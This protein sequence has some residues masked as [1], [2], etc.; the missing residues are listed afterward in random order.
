MKLALVLPVAL[1]A[2]ASCRKV[3]VIGPEVE[4]EDGTTYYWA[5]GDRDAERVLVRKAPNSPILETLDEGVFRNVL[6]PV[7]TEGGVAWATQDSGGA[8]R[9]EQTG[10]SDL[11]ARV[12]LPDGNS[13]GPGDVVEIKHESG[14]LAKAFKFSGVVPGARVRVV[15]M[16]GLT[17]KIEEADDD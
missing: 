6:G 2:L 16:D 13:Y 8:W 9:V 4:A 14:L 1:L 3:V 11:I 5:S 12:V 15:A 7:P 17:L 10:V